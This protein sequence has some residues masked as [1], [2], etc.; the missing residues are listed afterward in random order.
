MQANDLI[1][2]HQLDF[3]AEAQPQRWKSKHSMVYDMELRLSETSYSDFTNRLNLLYPIQDAQVKSFLEQ[4]V[5]TGR[6]LDKAPPVEMQL[7]E[8][9][10][11]FTM[12]SRK[13]AK[14][15]VWLVKGQGQV[16]INGKVMSEYFPE[17]GDREDIVRPFQFTKSVLQYN[18]WALV[19]GGGPTGNIN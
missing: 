4:F 9:G 5:P 19:Q 14:A 3:R 7:D 6:T 15:Q 8:L 18:V 12:A 10:R 13:T 2:T 16:Y 11:S 17:I 1:R